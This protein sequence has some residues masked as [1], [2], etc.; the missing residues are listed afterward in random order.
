M[1]VVTIAITILVVF[2]ILVVV[3]FILVVVFFIL[4]ILNYLRRRSRRIGIQ[5]GIIEE[6]A[7]RIRQIARPKMFQPKLKHLRQ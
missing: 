3:F 1:T 2:F 6:F 4:L 7:D 5:E